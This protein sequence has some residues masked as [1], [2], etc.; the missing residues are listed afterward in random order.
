MNIN[1]ALT[2]YQQQQ[3]N[4]GL[5]PDEAAAIKAEVLKPYQ[6]YKENL[7]EYQKA[8]LQT[9]KGKFRVSDKTRAEL[10]RLQQLLGLRD[11]DAAKIAASHKRKL[12]LGNQFIGIL[13]LGIISFAVGEAYANLLQTGQGK[14]MIRQLQETG[15]FDN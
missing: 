2:H 4:L 7:Q 3:K 11:E 5:T 8:F 14:N 12:N 9:I 1:P 15:G 10:K 6:D 13:S